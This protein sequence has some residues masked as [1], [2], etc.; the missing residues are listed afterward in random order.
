M[1]TTHRS[2]PKY[3]TSLSAPPRC[4]TYRRSRILFAPVRR[5]CHSPAAAPSGRP[6]RCACSRRAST[7]PGTTG[8]SSAAGRT[9]AAQ[10]TERS[11]SGEV[12]GARPRLREGAEQL[13]PLSNKTNRSSPVC[14]CTRKSNDVESVRMFFFSVYRTNS[15]PR[16][17]RPW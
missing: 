12:P 9:C 15:P 16:K 1:E 8:S 3:A 6:R 7:A 13:A 4:S 10:K 11:G 17:S 14:V 2:T 5:S